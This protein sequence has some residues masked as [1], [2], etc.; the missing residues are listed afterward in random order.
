MVDEKTTSSPGKSTATAF[1][2]QL[3][4]KLNEQDKLDM[5]RR[6][7]FTKTSLWNNC[8]RIF[9]YF[10]QCIHRLTSI[11]RM[12]EHGWRL[13]HSSVFTNNLFLLKCDPDWVWRGVT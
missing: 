6:S 13:T 8:R 9:S 10:F 5:L 4:D 11:K 3:F 1:A 2:A 12:T 7:H